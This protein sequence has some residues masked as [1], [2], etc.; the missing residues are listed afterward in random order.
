MFTAKITEGKDG[1][2]ENPND[3]I[4]YMMD[5][6]LTGEV[7]VYD[8]NENIA[9]AKTS[10][11]YKVIREYNIGKSLDDQILPTNAFGFRGIAGCL[12]V[13]VYSIGLGRYK[14]NHDKIAL[15]S[16]Y[17]SSVLDQSNECAQIIPGMKALSSLA[18]I[19]RMMNK[20]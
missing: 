13:K 3:A 14:D 1:V 11:I 16:G 6:N 8:T 5:N 18:L 2:F 7:S 15:F 17:N 12:G 10:K 19:G 9:Y 4:K 20:N